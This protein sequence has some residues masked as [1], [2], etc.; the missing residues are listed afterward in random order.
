MDIASISAVVAVGGVII[1][2]VLAYLEIRNLVKARRTDVV[3]RLFASFSTKE[4]QEAN[5]VV[6]NSRFE[7]YDDFV[8]KYGSF[9]SRKPIHIAIAMIAQFFEGLGVLVHRKLV[10]ISLVM[11]L[12]AIGWRWKKL[13]PLVEEL[14]IQMN[15]PRVMAWFE[16]LYNEEKKREQTLQAAL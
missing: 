4:F 12:Y 10:D 11:D 3:M 6:L 15:E 5:S 14:R 2:V 8:E 1:G 16:Y 7:D 9:E 13:K